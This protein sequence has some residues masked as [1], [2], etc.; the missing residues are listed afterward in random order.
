MATLLFRVKETF[1]IQGRGLVLISDRAKRECHFR[2]LI[3][4]QIE[5]RN[6]NIPS[7]HT[8]VAGIE[9]CDRARELGVLL[10]RAVSKAD[11]ESG[12]EVWQIGVDEYK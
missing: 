10:P 11:V 6:K 9:I 1:D 12:A 5:I 4:D 3:G 2:L 8:Q 7:V